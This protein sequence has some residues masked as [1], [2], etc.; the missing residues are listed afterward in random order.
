[1]IWKTKKKNG[2]IGELMTFI[3]DEWDA[4]RERAAAHPVFLR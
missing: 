4:E 2:G 1:M 3:L